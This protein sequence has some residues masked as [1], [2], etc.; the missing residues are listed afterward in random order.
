[1]SGELIILSA[2][3]TGGHVMPAQALALDLTSRGFKVEVFTDKRGLK[4]QSGFGSVPMREMRAGTLRAG[5]AGKVR[6]VID[7]AFG[8]LQAKKQI[9]KLKPVAIV[10]F[11][12][13]PSVPAVFAGQRMGI[14]TIL[15]EQNAIAGKANV[16][17]ARKAVKIAISMPTIRGLSAEE[18]KRA[19]YTGNPVRAEIAALYNKPYPSL[20]DTGTLRVLVMGGSLGA[21]VFSKIL[22]VTLTKLTPGNR[23]RLHIIQQ[24]READIEEARALYKEAGIKA[25]LST[26]IDDVAGELEKCHLVIARSGASTVAEVTVAGRP[27]IFV[28][29]PHHKDQ[30]QK[31]NAD[32]VADAG[33]AWTMTENGFTPE[34]LLARIETFLQNPSVLFKAAENAR[35]CGKPD[36]ARKLGNLVTEIVSGWNA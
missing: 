28:P 16:M 24:C 26:F 34:A 29:Y 15:H 25:E 30:Q 20:T 5:I 22:P 10:G 11:G 21:T 7:L 17:L 32:T 6:G 31:I 8:V 19:I 9:R 4:F 23:A 3:G 18:Q 1:M 2:G 36:A 27:A 13:Y 12:G 33:G 35:S 14:P